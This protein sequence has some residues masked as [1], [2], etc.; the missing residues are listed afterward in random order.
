MITLLD[1]SRQVNW[2]FPYPGQGLS[3]YPTLGSTPRCQSSELYS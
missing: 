3:A 2:K 1:G